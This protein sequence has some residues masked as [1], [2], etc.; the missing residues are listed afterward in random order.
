VNT[1]PILP[2]TVTSGLCSYPDIGEIMAS[3]KEKKKVVGFNATQVALEAG[4]AQAMN[5]VM[6]GTVS[7]YLP[8]SAVHYW[9]V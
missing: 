7:N 9:N 3:L 4:N 6:V 1:A 2:V 8:V 5:V